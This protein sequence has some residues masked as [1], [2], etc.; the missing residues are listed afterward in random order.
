MYSKYLLYPGIFYNNTFF[1]GKEYTTTRAR[2]SLGI[3]SQFAKQ[4]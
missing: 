2:D 4:N 1:S 3:A